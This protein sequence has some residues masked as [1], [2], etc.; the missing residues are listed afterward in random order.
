MRKFTVFVRQ[1]DNMGTTHVDC[2][3]A[4]SAEDAKK[5]AIA[6]AISDWGSDIF[7]EDHLHILGVAAGDVEL[8]E[9]DDLGA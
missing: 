6:Q 5:Q 1:F 2:Y 3:E 4:E 8:I 7:T 9:W